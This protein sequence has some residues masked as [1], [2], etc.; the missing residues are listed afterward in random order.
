M[1]LLDSLKRIFKGYYDVQFVNILT[2][3]VENGKNVIG[4]SNNSLFIFIIHGSLYTG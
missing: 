3:G 4:Y 2:I 1:G